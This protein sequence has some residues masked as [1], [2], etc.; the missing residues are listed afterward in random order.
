MM[1]ETFKYVAPVAGS[2]GYSAEDV[3][4]AVGLMANSGIKASQAGTSLRSSLTNLVQPTEAMMNV[5]VALGL[6]TEETANVVDSGKLQKAQ[7]KV[8]NKTIDMEK[9]QIKYNDAVAKY[10]VNSSQAQTAAL[11]LEK[12]K[13]NLE[14]FM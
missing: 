4:L 2:L 9:A 8:E 14:D 7:T 1:G 10:G 5:M 13:N 12:T 3:A 11:N 6:A